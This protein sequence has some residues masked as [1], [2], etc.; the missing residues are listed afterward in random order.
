MTLRQARHPGLTR[1]DRDT[2]QAQVYKK[3]RSA[4]MT[5]SL[6]PGDPVTLRSLASAFGTSEMPVREALRQLLAEHAL[7][8]GPNRA[9]VVPMLTAEQLEEVRVIRVALEGMLAERAAALVS[10]GDIKKLKVLHKDATRLVR[11]GDFKK[12]LALNH[13][14]HFLVY[15]AAGLPTALSIVESMWLR[16]GPALN[17]LLSKAHDA[18]KTST[19]EEIEQVFER[20]HEHVV[21]A[22]EHRD[23]PAAR[24]AIADDINDAADYFLS[25]I[26]VH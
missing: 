12:Y 16:I 21:Q 13:K 19:G 5:G 4:L 3:L 9:I 22:L 11:A 1:V 2:V 23:G 17:F 14:F 25:L 24:Q 15:S 26:A 10:A 8:S 18:E 6:A 7:V 20:N